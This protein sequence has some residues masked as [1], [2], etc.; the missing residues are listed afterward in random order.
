[1]T[2]TCFQKPL[3][4]YAGKALD[5]LRIGILGG[6]FDPVHNGHIQM[7]EAAYGAFGLSCVLMIPC[8]LPPHKDTEKV[9]PA[10]HRLQML[11]IACEAIP[12]FEVNDME[13]TREGYTYSVDTLRELKRIYPVGTELYYIVGS[14]TL[15][16]LIHWRD[17]QKV[18]GLTQFIV[19][20]RQGMDRA[21]MFE[22]MD[23][24]R[25]EFGAQIHLLDVP[26]LEISS[27]QIRSMARKEQDMGE[28]LPKRVEEYIRRHCVYGVEA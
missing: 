5:P 17:Y 11:R 13:I 8:G 12:Y 27:T 22:E 2:Q 9:T 7:G 21:P 24:L 19:I 15:C 1:M 4:Q 28:Y 10:R 14:D 3:A 20:P 26:C 23:R 16:D 6:T 25:R 18:F